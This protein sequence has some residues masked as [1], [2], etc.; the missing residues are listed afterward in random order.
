[1]MKNRVWFT[2]QELLDKISIE[3]INMPRF[4]HDVQTSSNWF[5]KLIQNQDKE[6]AVYTLNDGYSDELIED[7]VN[8]LM[9]IVYNR[10]ATDYVAYMKSLVY[11]ENAPLNKFLDNI[12]NVLNLT[13]P[14]YIPILKD[15]EVYSF[16]PIAPNYDES[17]E[18]FE[19]DNETDYSGN[20][21]SNSNGTQRMNDTPQDGGSFED[22]EHTS[23]FTGT[24]NSVENASS[25]NNKDN[26][27]SK[28]T[29]NNVQNV[30]SL[31]SRLVEMYNNFESIILKWS[32][33]FNM[34]FFKEE[35]I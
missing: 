34:L 33:E 18:E 14:K 16:D 25:Y 12:I 9:G 5:T 10:H 29:R 28:T 6:V 15:N 11:E 27:K 7:V 13:I 35:Q 21:N 1:M 4:P 23:N 32:N 31:M 24:T 26:M 22:D 20:N 8:A 2:Y 19:G 17:S 3:D 30:G